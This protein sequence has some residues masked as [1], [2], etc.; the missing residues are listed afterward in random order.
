MFRVFT[1]VI[2]L[3]FTATLVYAEKTYQVGMLV[4]YKSSETDVLLTQLR[5][6]IKAVVGED[7][8]I[9]FP[10]DKLLVNNGVFLYPELLT[11][12]TLFDTFG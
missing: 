12:H 8:N 5:T 6:E 4:D 7:A 10:I 1:V 9:T 11:L 3:I 2:F